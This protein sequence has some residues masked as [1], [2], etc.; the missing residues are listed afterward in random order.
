MKDKDVIEEQINLISNTH[1][2]VIFTLM[3]FMLNDINPSDLYE[4]SPGGYYKEYFQNKYQ[5]KLKE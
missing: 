1:W 3:E 4:Y 5:V 2:D